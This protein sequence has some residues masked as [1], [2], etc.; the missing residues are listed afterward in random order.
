MTLFRLII[1]FPTVVAILRGDLSIALVLAFL[2]SVSDA[3]DG[4]FAR[5]NGRPN[6][7]GKILDPYV[8]KVFALSIL[9]A[10][11][12]TGMVSPIPVVLLLFRDLSVS[13]LRTVAAVQGVIL[14]A[15]LLGKV[16][17]FLEFTSII[18]V[19]GGLSVG[20]VLLWCAVLVSYM[21][22]YEYIRSYLKASSGLNYP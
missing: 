22:V 9:V 6:G 3:M 20:N 21:S 15:S 5:K 17:T 4:L 14:E 12:A 18:A 7:I 13:F 16:K 11:V 19:L 2:G 1:T 10:L 8:D